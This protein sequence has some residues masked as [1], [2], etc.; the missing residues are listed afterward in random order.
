MLNA[1]ILEKLYYSEL[2]QSLSKELSQG[3]KKAQYS[4]SSEFYQMRLWQLSTMRTETRIYKPTDRVKKKKK[5]SLRIVTCFCCVQTKWL[6]NFQCHILFQK[7]KQ[8]NKTHQVQRLFHLSI[9]FFTTKWQIRF[10][11]I[12]RIHEP[13]N[14]FHIIRITSKDHKNLVSIKK[15]ES[16]NSL[17]T[18][19]K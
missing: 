11:R 6:Q 13:T 3:Y 19:K 18:T 10:S 5:K 2:K 4:N 12:K 9:F 8:K 17:K 16:G 1:N 14:V 7:K 15:H